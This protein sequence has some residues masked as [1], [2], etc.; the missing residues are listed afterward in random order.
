MVNTHPHSDHFCPDTVKQ[1]EEKGAALI[2]FAAFEEKKFG[3]YTG[4][5]AAGKSH[6]GR[7]S[8]LPC[9]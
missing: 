1:M 5:R 7:K 4:H 8:V 6:D 2:P 3:G 9:H